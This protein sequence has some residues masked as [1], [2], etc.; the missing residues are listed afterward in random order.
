MK[1]IAFV[2]SLMMLISF[3]ALGD[4]VNFTAD[5]P[6]TVAVGDQFRLS[7]T[8]TTQDV[9]DFRAPSIK[10][11]EVLMG[12]SR[13]QQSSVQIINGKTSSTSSITFTYILLANTEG[14]YTI[15]GATILADGNK[16][17]SNSVQIK[18]LPAD[19]ASGGGASSGDN[20]S[21]RGAA[22]TSN[23]TAVS[24]NELFVTAT[25]SKS[26]VYE[27]EALLLTYK[28]Y[29]LVDLRGF[30]N[31]K[32][33]DFKGFHSQEVEL[34][35]NRKWNLEHYKGRNYRSTI[36]RQFVL[37]PQQTG[38]IQIEPARFDASVAKV[39]QTVDPFEAFFNGGSNY[40]EVKKT[41]LTPRLTVDV[42]SLPAANKPN[43]FS[44]GVGD[45]NI[46][47][48]ISSNSLKTNDAV[49]IKIDVSGVGNMK[50]LATPEIKF[51]ED[52]EV[53]DPKVDNNFKLTSNGLHGTKTIEYLAIPRTAGKYTIPALNFSYFDVK[54]R[55]YKTI[56]TEAYELNVEKG[57]G[58]ATQMVANFNNK[59]DLK[60]LNEDIRFIKQNE[61]ELSPRGNF[62]FGS[63]EYWLFY[64][65]PGLAFALSFFIYR[66]HIAFN[67]NTALVKTKKANK[68][69]KQRLKYAGKLLNEKKCNDFYDEI[70]KALWGYIGDK[71][72]I[73]VSQLSKENV[74]EKL[75]MS[76]VDDELIQEFMDVLNNCEFARFAPGDANATM[77]KIYK[78]SLD[79]ISRIENSI[80]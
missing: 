66:R 76:G 68:V 6:E 38:K 61:V 69:A 9:K 67:S 19:K 59:E 54:S 43:D 26:N 22:G 10:G 29:T 46:T 4:N 62:F 39:S 51:P 52:F 16:K 53:Y 34:S 55:S 12:P 73:Q 36:Y 31:V 75:K 78:E 18:V 56:S 37:F 24:S 49:T 7:Y 58:D 23:S 15:P 60:V 50:L 79:V 35:D 13:S 33:P 40:V 41:L 5:A 30:D 77:D 65:I 63:W 70:M 17:I 48:S 20:T 32:L 28:I 25:V 14:S 21:N 27:Q 80:K 64:L 44:G 2:W 45:F 42:K 3:H 74:E 1:K 72:N 71:L 8:V 11:F 57:A 47:S